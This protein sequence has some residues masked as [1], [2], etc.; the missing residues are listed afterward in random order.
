MSPGHLRLCAVLCEDSGRAVHFSWLLASSIRKLSSILGAG[1]PNFDTRFE[2][3]FANNWVLLLWVFLKI[4][5]WD[6]KM[7]GPPSYQP[8]RDPML[9]SCLVHG[10]RIIPIFG[11]GSDPHTPRKETCDLS[12]H[13]NHFGI[14]PCSGCPVVSASKLMNMTARIH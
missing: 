6:N 12:I 14:Q 4:S 9:R 13:W 2:S 11:L 3:A 8:K 1:S 5:E 10:L 7:V